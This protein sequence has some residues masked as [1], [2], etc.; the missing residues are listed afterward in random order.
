LMLPREVSIKTKVSGTEGDAAEKLFADT[1]SVKS[2]I[3]FSCFR[4]I[5][6]F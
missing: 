2:R 1:T 5:L 4:T 3:R 6:I